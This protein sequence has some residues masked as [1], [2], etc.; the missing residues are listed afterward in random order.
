MHFKP[1][2]EK[3]TD[4]R[5]RLTSF[6][7]N[8]NFLL[9]HQGVLI[10]SA[11]ATTLRGIEAKIDKLSHF[12]AELKDEPEAVAEDF[13]ASNGGEDNVLEVSHTRA[14]PQ[15]FDQYFQNDTLI[16]Q[17]AKRLNLQLTSSILR[18]VKEGADESFNQS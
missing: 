8:L 9:I 17:L 15:Y 4:F 5:T 11:N 6:K 2:A 18:A 16:D 13:I 1:N 7:T 3:L 14:I 10:A 12:F